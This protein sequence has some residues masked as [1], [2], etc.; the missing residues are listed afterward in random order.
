MPDEFRA[1]AVLMAR[2]R[3]LGRRVLR[4][5]T[6]GRSRRSCS[7][8]LLVRGGRAA[9]IVEVEAYCGAE[10]PGSHAYR[11]MTRRNATMFGPP[12]RLYVYFTYGMHW[13]AN[14]VCGRD[15]RGRRGAPAG[16]RA[17]AGLD[18]MRARR[19]AARR[20]RDLLSGPGPPVPGLRA[21]R[22]LRRRRPRHRR[23]G[24]HDRRRRHAAA[25]R[26]R[27]EHPD[28]PVGRAPSSRGAGAPPARSTS[29]SRHERAALAPRELDGPD[30]LAAARPRCVAARPG[31][32][33]PRGEPAA[34]PRLPRRAPRRAAPVVP[35]GPPHRLGGGGRPE[36][37]PGAPAVPRQG[38]A[39]AAAGRARRRRRQPGARRAPGGRGGDRHRRAPGARPRPS[40][41][42]STCS[43]TPRAREPDHLHLDVRHLV[44]G[45]ARRR[46]RHATRS[47]RALRWVAGRRRSR[48][49]DVDPGTAPDGARRAVAALDELGVGTAQ[50]S[51]GVAQAG[52]WLSAAKASMY[53]VTCS[54]SLAVT[55]SRASGSLPQRV[56]V[57]LPVVEVGAP[58]GDPLRRRSRRP[59]PSGASGSRSSTMAANRSLA[60]STIVGPLGGA[61]RPRR[62][63]GAGRRRRGRPRTSPAP[64]WRRPGRRA[65]P[66]AAAGPGR[67]RGRARSPTWPPW[68][69][70]PRATSTRPRSSGRPR[71]RALG[72]GAVS[73]VGHRA[74]SL[75]S[76]RRALSTCRRPPR[77]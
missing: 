35:R 34:D 21:R 57:G 43:T 53:S 17:G 33:E 62:P 54:R 74:S 52:M 30:D 22:R 1:A 25:R 20:D 38:A 65:G 11:G 70:R 59:R 37:P 15:G 73:G 49:L 66:A 5:A 67:R 18:E 76:R 47:R 46:R 61:S 2:R 7:G 32:A 45:P 40:T 63:A 6:R 28:R 39:L 77:G 12:G 48:P 75:V 41:S 13:C 71:R 27:R 10:D 72:G 64:R 56:G 60:W 58:V 23:P 4:G 29:R 26:A 9:R 14:A 44:R 55:S 24:R 8:K 31:D 42:T 51:M 19:P 69:R 3:R 16:G 36:H 68:P 50:T